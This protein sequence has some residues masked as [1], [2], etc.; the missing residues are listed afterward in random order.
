MSKTLY[1]Y[2]RNI[3]ENLPLVSRLN[4]RV[5]KLVVKV[6]KNAPNTLIIKNRYGINF[7]NY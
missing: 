4:F 3:A 1:M 7:S 6:K 5:N 2:I